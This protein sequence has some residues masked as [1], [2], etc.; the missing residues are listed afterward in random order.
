VAFAREVRDERGV[1]RVAFD[2]EGSSLGPVHGGLMANETAMSVSIRL[3]DETK[4]ERVR[5]SLPDLRRELS[6]L[7]LILQYLGVNT[8]AP[9]GEPAATDYYGLDMEI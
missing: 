3:E 5:R 9:G 2:Y 7:P 1:W 8:V 6:S 4:A